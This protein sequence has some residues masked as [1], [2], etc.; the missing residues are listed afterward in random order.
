MIIHDVNPSFESDNLEY[1]DYGVV[2]V[3]KGGYSIVDVDIVFY[4][5]S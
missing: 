2:K 3:V 1:C 5:V 4:I